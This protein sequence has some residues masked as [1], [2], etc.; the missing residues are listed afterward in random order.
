MT[1]REHS[2]EETDRDLVRDEGGAIMVMGVFMAV[3]LVGMIYYVSGIGETVLYRERMQDASDAGAFGAAV[4]HAR[5]MNIISLLNMV[6]A[7][8]LAVLVALKIVEALITAALL[9]AT[10]ICAG[11]G[12]ACGG[13]CYA[14]P[15]AVT[16][17]LG[18]EDVA[19]TIASVEPPIQNVVSLSN[20]VAVGVREGM[21]LAAQAKVVEYGAYTFNEPTRAGFMYPI[22]RSLPTEDDD[23]NLLCRKAGQEA[24]VIAL[25][26][27]VRWPVRRFVS[28]ATGWLAATFSGYFCG[29]GRDKAQR[30][31]ED[32]ELGDESFQLR[33]FMIGEPPFARSEQGV[34]IAAWGQDERSA[35]VD[36]LR[37]LGRVSFAQAEFYYADGDA[38]RREW[39]W[40]MEWRARLRRFR[41]PGDMDGIGSIC[42]GGA[43]CGALGTLTGVRDVV[44]H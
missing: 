32:A 27:L 8:V 21:P 34:A 38:D 9:I 29:E 11:C 43:G 33:A 35:T 23:S 28:P 3:L 37:E 18:R 16:L 22:I 36:V 30:I 24:A 40:H 7:A 2:T 42:G 1:R 44:V 41:M 14:C 20:S 12:P 13:C 5:G 17:E 39:L 4:M 26:Q 19:A 31:L 10:A 25:P 6:M 15:L